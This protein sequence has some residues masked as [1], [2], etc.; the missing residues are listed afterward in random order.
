MLIYTI[1]HEMRTHADAII[2]QEVHTLTTWLAFDNLNLNKE[3]KALAKYI[4][5]V[6]ARSLDLAI[7][8][9]LLNLQIDPYIFTGI[10]RDRNGIVVSW[11][12]LKDFI[13]NIEVNPES[14]LDMVLMSGY[15]E[16]YD[17]LVKDPHIWLT[18]VEDALYDRAQAV[19]GDLEE[20]M[21]RV[22]T[23]MPDLTTYVDQYHIE[24]ASFCNGLILFS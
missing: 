14:H 6:F 15:D 4:Q 16:S 20:M 2:T 24:Y 8:N 22:E 5:M 1:P 3:S 23:A 13:K 11:S 21:V 10:K 12:K 18:K 9:R 7:T 19:V 17:T